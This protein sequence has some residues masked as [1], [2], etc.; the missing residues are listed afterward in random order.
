MAVIT[1][2]IR[3]IAETIIEFLRCFLNP[4]GVKI[5][6]IR[7]MSNDRH[8]IKVIGVSDN[9]DRYVEEF[10]LPPSRAGSCPPKGSTA[11]ADALD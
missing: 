3:D 1:K 4:P 10:P 9:N 5:L 6:R 11:V 7:I 8:S 2:Q